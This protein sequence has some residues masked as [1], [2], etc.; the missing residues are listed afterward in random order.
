MKKITTVAGSISFD[1]LGVCQCHEHLFISKGVSYEVNPYL[2]MDDLQKTIAEVLSYKAAGGCSLIDAQPVGCNRMAQELRQ[3][4][5]ETGVSI[6][7]ATGFHKLLFYP[8]MHWIKSFSENELYRI[9]LSELQEGMYIQCDSRNPEIQVS[10]CA[11]LVKAA[12]DTEGLEGRYRKLFTAAAHAA[13]E[14]DVPMMVHMEQEPDPHQLLEFLLSEGM[15]PKRLIF[16]HMDRSIRKQEYYTSI[17][18]QGVTL[19][20]DTIGRFKYHSDEEETVLIKQLLEAGY[21]RILCSLDT[22]RQRMKTY[23]KEAIG[24]DYLL[25]TF[26]PQLKNAGVSEKQLEKI[27]TINSKNVFI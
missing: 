5:L 1:E 12:Y 4:S 17:M 11:G 22:T 10:Y 7:A 6:V 21:D 2:Y 3:T 24:L 25:K 15:D 16:C 14:A 26:V 23:T 19:E 13:I 8:E 20:F 27:L 18:S 9:Y